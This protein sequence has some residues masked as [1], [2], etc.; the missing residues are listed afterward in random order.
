M[1]L[2]LEVERFRTEFDPPPAE[3]AVPAFAAVE[4]AMPAS[5]ETADGRVAGA[6]VAASAG[7]LEIELPQGARVRI[8]GDVAP[9]VVTAALR[10]LIRR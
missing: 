7:V 2:D 4:L 8:S 9:A 1:N 10:A 6:D 5:T 3:P